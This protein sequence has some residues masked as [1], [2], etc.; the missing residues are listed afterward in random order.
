MSWRDA[1]ILG[2]L[3]VVVV[4][5]IDLSGFMDELKGRL[6][7]W[8]GIRGE[9]SLKPFDCSF[10]MYHHTA[11]VVMLCLG[12]LTLAAYMAICLGALLTGTVRALLVAILDGLN[13]LLTWRRKRD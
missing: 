7:R 8:L 3:L 10:C 13:G 5:L 12:R 4:V 6:A 11:L 1:E 2:E 9:V